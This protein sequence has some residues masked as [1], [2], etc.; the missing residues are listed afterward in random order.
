MACTPDSLRFHDTRV[1]ARVHGA[2]ESHPGFL[3]TQHNK[4]IEST[5]KS[6]VHADEET[7]GYAASRAPRL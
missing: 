2:C 3:S 7:P 4:K 6:T 1:V 5:M